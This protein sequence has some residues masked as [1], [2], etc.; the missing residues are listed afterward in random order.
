METEQKPG[1]ILRNR[2]THVII[3]PHFYENRKEAILS[4]HLLLLPL[5]FQNDKGSN[6]NMMKHRFLNFGKSS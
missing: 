5:S 4:T 6:I 2:F 1:I 3:R